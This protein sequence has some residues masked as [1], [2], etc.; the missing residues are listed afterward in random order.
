MTKILVVWYP[1][2]STGKNMGRMI[3][4][5]SCIMA[6]VI[7]KPCRFLGSWVEDQDFNLFLLNTPSQNNVCCKLDLLHSRITDFNSI[8][9]T[10]VKLAG[11]LEQVFP[12][13][14]FLLLQKWLTSICLD[15]YHNHS[16][17]V[18]PYA[19]SVTVMKRIVFQIGAFL[20]IVHFPVTLTGIGHQNE[21]HIYCFTYLFVTTNRSY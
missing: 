2:L 11:C 5:K 7:M 18:K 6:L 13:L 16:V 14:S 12:I 8:F 17:E 9:F 10:L 1:L 20:W 15:P 19:S 21:Y 4:L 3:P